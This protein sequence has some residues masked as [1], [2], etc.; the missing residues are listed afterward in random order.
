MGEDPKPVLC[1]VLDVFHDHRYGG[2]M[3]ITSDGRD[4]EWILVSDKRIVSQ[5]I[6]SLCSTTDAPHQKV[7]D[8]TGVEVQA[9]AMRPQLATERDESW[10]KNQSAVASETASFRFKGGREQL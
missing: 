5:A 6:P 2:R 9:A 8:A 7:R 3:E 10:S 1:E 4:S